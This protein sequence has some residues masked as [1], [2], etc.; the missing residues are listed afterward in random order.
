V[1]D[2]PE[3]LIPLVGERPSLLFTLILVPHVLAGLTCVLTGAI[4]MLSPKRRGRHP[5]FGDVYYWSLGVVFVSATCLAV[6]R[7]EHDG[8]L[9]VLGTLA[10]GLGSVGY[11]ARKRRWRGWTSAHVVGMGLSYIVLLT[12]FYVDNGPNLPLWNRLPTI[13]FWVGPSLI[14]LPL[15]ARALVRHTRPLADVRATAQ[16]LMRSRAASS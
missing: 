9:F 4:A 13:A 6:L 10:F 11:V 16:Q 2:L 15:L 5:S 3:L 8:Y 14:G 1:P 7:W 12:A